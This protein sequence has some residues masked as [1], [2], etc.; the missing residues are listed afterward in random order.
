MTS[1]HNVIPIEVKSSKDYTTFSLDRFK[2]KYAS[3]AADGYVLHP[4]DVK[5]ARGITYL[6]LYMTPLLTTEAFRR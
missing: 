6:P 2:S 3:I 5:Q 1:R 4:G